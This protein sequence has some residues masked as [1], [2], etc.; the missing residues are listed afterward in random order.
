MVCREVPDRVVVA[1]C[2][3]L[4]SKAELSALL[5]GLGVRE[6]SA[7]APSVPTVKAAVRAGSLSAAE[8]LARRAV[9]QA[10]AADV[11]LLLARN[12]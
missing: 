11:R 4:A 10:G 7:V 9:D 5:V 6:L 3:D 8:D 2:G 1:V 12:G